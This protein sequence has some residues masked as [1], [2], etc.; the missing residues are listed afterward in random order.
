VRIGVN[1]GSLDQRL[2]TELMDENSRR[3]EPKE[4][5][6]GPA[7]A[8]V[9]SAIRSATLAERPGSDTTASCCRQ[10]LVRA[11]LIQV[12]GMLAERSDYPLHLGSPK[13]GSDEGD[14]RE[15][16]RARAA[17]LARD[18]RYDPRLAHASAGGDPCR[19]GARR[20]A[21]P[22]E[23]RHPELR[24]AG[25]VVPRRGRTTSTFFQQMAEDITGYIRD[26]MPE[27]RARYPGVEELDVA[28][29]GC[30]VNGPGEAGTRTSGSR[31][32]ERP[33]DPRAPVYVDGRHVTTLQGDW[34][35]RGVQA[36]PRRLRA[37]RYGAG[38]PHRGLGPG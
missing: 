11:D 28:V 21:D 18:R 20:A 27:W 7:Q 24:A 8:M 33:E 25:D 13:P 17:A 34:A 6:E 19:G 3:P 10:G 14:R 29:M 1:W 9:E 38:G 35:G 2:L 30:V 12:Y 15:R 16:D 23:P 5:R 36:H 4:A 22:A 32:R 26:R 31:C 37:Q